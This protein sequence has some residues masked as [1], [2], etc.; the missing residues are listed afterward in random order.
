MNSSGRK[1]LTWAAILTRL[2]PSRAS[3]AA[4]TPDRPTS[5]ALHNAST[6]K[7]AAETAPMPVTTTLVR[8][9][10]PTACKNPLGD[11]LHE[12]RNV[13]RLGDAAVDRNVN[14]EFL[15]DRH[16]DHDHIHRLHLE[17][18]KRCLGGDF[19]AVNLTLADDHIQDLPSQLLVLCRFFE[20]APSPADAPCDI[21]DN[22]PNAAAGGHRFRTRLEAQIV[23]LA[24]RQC[25]RAS[26]SILP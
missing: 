4:R 7:P 8:G 1:P 14:A 2:G 5:A 21:S 12:A 9:A 23:K 6:P 26:H 13:S 16:E 22:L 25:R 19:G 3:F 24:F 18:L 17:A 11:V 15:L 10:S 20:Q